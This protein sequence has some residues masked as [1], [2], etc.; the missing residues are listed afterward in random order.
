VTPWHLR[1]AART[2][3]AGGIVACPTE[4]VFGLHC[5][6]L[7][8]LAVERIWALK[9]R[10][11]RKGLLLLAARIDQLDPYMALPDQAAEERL[12]STWPGPVT[13]V[14]PAAPLAPDWLTGG[15]PTIAVRVTDHPVAAALCSA[16]GFA[17][18]S[19]SANLSG[20]RPARSPLQVRKSFGRSLDYILHAPT[21][22]R[23]G[24]TE[25]R[26]LMD[27]KILRSG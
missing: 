11:V 25:I 22:G 15:R 7:A 21:G 2:I 26:S 27:G 19:T 18:V 8:P 12:R 23:R 10:P 16:C 3:L 24:P 4:G 17:L 20:H 6:P 5:D 1:R 13:W 9:G 14:V